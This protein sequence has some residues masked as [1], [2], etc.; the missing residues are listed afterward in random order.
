MRSGTGRTT[1]PCP[2]ASGETAR[3]TAPS[4]PLVGGVPAKVLR[5]TA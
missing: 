5:R 2:A 4:P 1:D 3:M